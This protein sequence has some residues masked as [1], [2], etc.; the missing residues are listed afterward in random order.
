MP[1]TGQEL[2]QHARRRIPG[3]TQLLSKRPEMLLPE[4]WPSYYSRAA[5]SAIWDLDGKRYVDMSYSGIGSC[6]L[7]YAD[8]DVDAAVRAAIDAG[9]MSTLNCAE[10]VELADLLCELHPWAAMVRYARCGGEAMAVAVRIARA[11]TRRVKVAVCGYHGWHDWYLAANLGSESALGHHLLPG[12]EPNGVPPQLAGTTFTFHYNRI[13]ELQAIVREHGRDL[14]AIVMEPIRNQPP[15]AGFLEEVRQIA[16]RT[17][18]VLVF[19]EVT[20]AWRLNS[21][22]SHLLYGVA[23]DVAVFA[24]AISNGYPMAAIIGSE[25]VMQ[26]AQETFISS[27]YWTERIGP[28]AALA[29]IKKHR[30]LEVPLHLERIGKKVQ[31]CWQQA[32]EHTGLAI[33]VSGLP[34]LA[35]FSIQSEQA[36]AVRT[37]FTQQMLERGFLATNA[38]YANYAHSD[39]EVEQYATAVRETFAELADAI[40]LGAVE[41]RL[42]G[43]VAHV[44]FSRLT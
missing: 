40:K 13:D 6:I 44:G 37:L 9:S 25:T 29:T 31:A 22:G 28:T 11:H 16:D 5:G 17:S 14:A 34:Q 43:P 15:Q 19:D 39:Q 38:Y 2:Y 24:K 30:A 7:G 23:P 36:Q 20:S 10:E 33:S 26:A 3:G 35:H 27:T 1:K 42:Q 8:P 21:G 41:Q 32:A 4:Q 12:L 18:C